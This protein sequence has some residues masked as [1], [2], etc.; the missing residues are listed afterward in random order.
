MNRRRVALAVLV[1][2]VVTYLSASVDAECILTSVRWRKQHA[3]FVFDG[4]VIKVDRIG[5]THESVA[6]IEVHRVWKGKVEKNTTVY[7]ERGIDGPVIEA[8]TR[9]VF[10]VS[11]QGHGSAENAP[12]RN[13]WVHPCGQ[14]VPYNSEPI[15]KELGRSRKPSN[16]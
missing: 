9:L 1:A 13:R 7:F 16:V 11:G 3:A 15:I 10:F 12:I 2:V 4:T 5:L 6:A 14:V 8:G